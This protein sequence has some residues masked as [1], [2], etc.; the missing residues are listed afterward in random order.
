MSRLHPTFIHEDK[1]GQIFG[2]ANINDVI[3]FVT[4]SRAVE[5]LVTIESNTKYCPVL[6]L[7]AQTGAGNI[8]EFCSTG[9][10]RILNCTRGRLLQCIAEILLQIMGKCSV[11]FQ[12]SNFERDMLAEF[13][14][15]QRPRKL[16]M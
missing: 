11:H 12:D 14:I 16:K 10:E 1:G 6:L 9:V 8:R 2:L 5:H 7:A 15:V 4:S 13:M 3:I